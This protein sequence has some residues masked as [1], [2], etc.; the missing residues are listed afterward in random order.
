MPQGSILGPLLFAIFI[1]D[2]EKDVLN[3]V[4]KFADDTKLIGKV[5]VPEKIDTGMLRSQD[6]PKIIG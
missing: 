3:K 1:N 2:L 5:G 6:R 4:L